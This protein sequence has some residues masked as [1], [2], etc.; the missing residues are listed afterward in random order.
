LPPTPVVIVAPLGEQA[1]QPAEQVAPRQTRRGASKVG[2]RS[3]RETGAHAFFLFSRARREAL[4][5]THPEM[6]RGQITKELG[7]EWRGM[8]DDEKA[9]WMMDL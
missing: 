5:M 7:V 9:K 2:G 8:S 4:K 3:P 1:G 6:T